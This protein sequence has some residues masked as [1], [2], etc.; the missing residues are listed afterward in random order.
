MTAVTGLSL[1]SYGDA[2]LAHAHAHHQIVL[3][4][5]GRLEM[6]V[7]GRGGRVDAAGLVVVAGGESH[8]CRATG[9]NRFLV[10]DWEGGEGADDEAE[11][12]VDSGQRRPFLDLDPELMPLLRYLDG[13]VTARHIGVEEGRE[14]GRLLLRRLGGMSGH[15]TE[16]S[17]RR[18][19]RLARALAY[20]QANLA[21]PLTVDALAGAAHTSAGHL[22]GLFR[23]HL[24]RAPMAHVAA[25]RL[26]RAMA[27][28]AASEATI[29]EIALSCGYSDQSA[30]TR[31]LKRRH[32]V[33]P[34]AYRRCRRS[35]LQ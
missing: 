10:L 7:A 5:E 19:R 17:S 34:A 30:L 8:S 11:R 22:H 33:T 28:L 12:L 20:A 26:E 18:P 6:E 29:A 35:A 1:R 24:G 14:W 9:A 4:L 25:L 15:G 16:A 13:A 21:A 3:G 23:R 32:G 2:P 31:A 27:R